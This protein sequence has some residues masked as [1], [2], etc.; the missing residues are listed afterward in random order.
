MTCLWF[1]GNG[2]NLG[3]RVGE[4]ELAH[5]RIGANIFIFDYR[6]Y[7]ESEGIPSEKG[8][9]LDSRAVIE[10]L[11]SRT[12]VD[13]DRLVYV[14]HSLGAAVAI[15]SALTTP[16][17][18]MVLISPFASMRDMANLTL[19]FAPAGWIVR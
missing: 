9:Y 15:E 17:M 11:C 14:G 4:L 10:Y 8:T 3:H 19:P 12:D 5:H 1:H 13:S 2:G 7:G 6:G 18:A 16:P